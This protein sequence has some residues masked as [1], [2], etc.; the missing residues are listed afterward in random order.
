MEIFSYEQNQIRHSCC[1]Y[2]YIILEL[3]RLILCYVK[4]NEVFS[5][6]IFLKKKKKLMKVKVVID[7]F[8]R[9]SLGGRT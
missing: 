3:L 6:S 2:K 1:N 7:A 9:V 8:F 5:L 4:V